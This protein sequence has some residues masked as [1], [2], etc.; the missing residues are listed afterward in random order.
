M[1][2]QLRR[3]Y[4]LLSLV[5]TLALHAAG[6]SFAPDGWLVGT[7]FPGKPQIATTRDAGV[8]QT[9]ATFDAGPS[10]FIAIRVQLVAEVPKDRVASTYDLGRDSML[11]SMDAQLVREEKITIA[12]HEGRKYLI[13]A[14]SKQHRAETHVVVI[15]NELYSFSFATN[16]ALTQ[17]VAV[18]FFK[19]M[20]AVGKGR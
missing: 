16:D 3:L 11:L 20:K 1:H 7:E 18:T 10:S 2:V 6:V 19:K 14:K 13:E 17:P 12:G 4:L 5:P 15:G 8:T 9:V